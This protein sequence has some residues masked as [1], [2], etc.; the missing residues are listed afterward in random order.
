[1]GDRRDRFYLR[2]GRIRHRFDGDIVFRFIGLNR[3]EIARIAIDTPTVGSI[4]GQGM[5]FDFGREL[6]PAFFTV[7]HY[8]LPPGMNWMNVPGS[9]WIG[10]ILPAEL[11]Y[12][13]TT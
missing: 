5:P 10:H 7:V 12:P 3:L 9:L 8:L 6:M 11:W 13:P 1:M 4:D 2:Y